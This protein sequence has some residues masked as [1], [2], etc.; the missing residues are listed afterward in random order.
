MRAATWSM[1]SAGWWNL[2]LLAVEDQKAFLQ[3]RVLDL[4]WTLREASSSHRSR[5]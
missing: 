5:F 3:A 4:I 1:R 2:P